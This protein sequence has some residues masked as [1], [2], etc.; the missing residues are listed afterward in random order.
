MNIFHILYDNIQ[1]PQHIWGFFLHN[2]IEVNF[3]KL[4]D[5]YDTPFYKFPKV[6]KKEL[7]KL[8]SDD[9]S[10]LLDKKSAYKFFGYKPSIIRAKDLNSVLWSNSLNILTDK[11]KEK[12]RPLNKVFQELS[13]IDIKSID[14]TFTEASNIVL[15]AS[16]IL[17]GVLTLKN[18]DRVL[19]R[20]F[21]WFEPYTKTGRLH[22]I[23]GNSINIL[24]ERRWDIIP[25]IDDGILVLL[26]FDGFHIRIMDDVL[27]INTIS[28]KQKAHEHLRD[29][30]NSTLDLPSFKKEVFRCLYSGDF[31]LIKH[32]WFRE[33]EKNIH[34]MEF[35]LPLH[36]HVDSYNKFNTIIQQHE[37]V[38]ISELIL[39]LKKEFKGNI[40]FELYLY[41]GVMISIHGNEL[42]NL[43]K[44]LL[45]TTD[46]YPLTLQTK[47][48]NKFIYGK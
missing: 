43:I 21:K 28:R 32:K 30:T 26:D 13:N 8:L 46:K 33:V 31:S 9:E 48:F 10:Y 39:N 15:G 24:K 5:L 2:G 11:P 23:A 42:E 25:S 27:G 16:S 19:E 1:S 40:A 12:F 47:S 6:E 29:I 22:D 38:K 18:G 35:L 3:F 7:K 36:N 14:N 45:D 17:D 44:Y 4:E 41:D 37:V 20:K 34:N